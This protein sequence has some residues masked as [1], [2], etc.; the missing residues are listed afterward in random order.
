[1]R[2]CFDHC[3]INNFGLV[4]ENTILIKRT[5]AFFNFYLEYGVSLLYSCMSSHNS[6]IAAPCGRMAEYTHCILSWQDTTVLM[7]VFFPGHKGQLWAHSILK[8]KLGFAIRRSNLCFIRS[9]CKCFFSWF[10]TRWV[11]LVCLTNAKVFGDNLFSPGLFS[12]Y[13]QNIN[14]KDILSLH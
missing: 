1:M 14:Y 4:F 8:N 2:Q 3:R 11:Q 12:I 10:Y 6:L 7:D 5:F 13:K 9:V